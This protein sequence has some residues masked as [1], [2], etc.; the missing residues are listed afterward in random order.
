MTASAIW[1]GRAQTVGD[2]IGSNIIGGLAGCVN[3]ALF[4]VT[5]S[6]MF[7]VHQRASAN[8]LY[9]AATAFGNYMGPVAA[10]YVAVSQGW[11]WT[12][13]YLTIFMGVTTL[14]MVFGLEESKF[15]AP[16]VNGRSV[17]LPEEVRDNSS[18]NSITPTSKEQTDLAL[19]TLT[20]RESALQN[21]SIPKDGYWR[22]HRLITL[23]S[24]SSAHKEKN[25]LI[26]HTFQPFII[27]VQFPAVAFTAL[28]Y[29]WLIS[30]L[31]VVAVTQATIYPAPPYNFGAASV[32]LMSLPPAIGSVLGSLLGGPLIDFLAIHIAKRRGGI[33]EPETRLW[34]FMFPSCCMIVGV[35]MY[36]LTIAKVCLPPYSKSLERVPNSG[37]PR[38]F[39]TDIYSPLRDSRGSST[40]SAPASLA[41]PSADAATWPSLMCRTR[42][43][44]YVL[45]F[46]FLAFL[47]LL[48]S[49]L[50][51]THDS[52][53]PRRC[54]RRGRLRPQRHQYGSGVR[55]PAVDHGHG[56]LRH[57]RHLWR[58]RGRLWPHVHPAHRLGS[59]MEDP[60]GRQ[61]FE[62]AGAAVLRGWRV[63]YTL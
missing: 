53:D 58:P 15:T 43:N 32:G 14:A 36:G 23:D 63:E 27:L 8:G 1:Q 40:P 44:M 48:V 47:F 41:S 26:R 25:S 5:V 52:P 50:V 19:H 42:I 16:P 56:R 21:S 33:H 3:E 18:H 13:Y 45:T 24:D 31:S 61:V 22:R 38:L 49:T 29:G 7:F 28:Q 10:G 6:D 51:L 46:R 34:L 2:F 35:L 20:T 12:F 54:P 11:R 57:V 39:S 37:Q 62:M 59:Q 4:Q 17:P 30:M 55:C 60:I 9:I